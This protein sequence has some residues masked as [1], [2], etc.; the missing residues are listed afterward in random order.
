MPVLRPSLAAFLFTLLCLHLPLARAQVPTVS[1]G[2][3]QL[4]QA[5][6]GTTTVFY[7]TKAP[8]SA[9]Q[10][11]PFALSWAA[12]AQPARGNG[13]LIVIS[14]GSGG[15]PWVH[16]DLSRVLVKRGF[17][18]AL[19]AHKGD[20]YL[21]DATP[22]PQSWLLRPAEVSRAIDAIADHPQLSSLLS[23]DA[24]GVFGGSA[25]G[26]TALSLAG[27]QWSPGRF[28]E[29]CL[30]YIEQDFSSCVGFTT[31][32]NGGWL[33]G[34]KLWVAKRVISWRF[35]DDTL[36]QDADARVVAAIAMVPFAADFV[37][38]SLATPRIAL[39]LVIADKD[40]NQVPSLHVEA[41]RR[42]CEPRCEV[43]MHLPNA[44]HGAMLSPAPPFKA[45]SIASK[46]LSDPPTFD[47]ATSLAGLHELIANFFTRKLGL[48][49]P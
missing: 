43:V 38:E 33:D 1:V 17:V 45:G 47:R 7:P 8:E 29:H 34:L 6:G 20:N 12:D 3:L 15:S 11:G 41:I 36:R 13:R 5:D 18:V 48:V 26:H 39:G 32:L 49:A 28:R 25:G 4:A 19:P 44:G 27:G 40:V 22:G 21:D 16:V 46:L 30:R 2:M 42:V 24:V 9:V 35:T 14:H 10:R 23:L 37:P 31:L